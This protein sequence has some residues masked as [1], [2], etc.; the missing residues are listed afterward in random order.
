MKLFIKKPKKNCIVKVPIVMQMNNLE[1][2]VASLAMILSY[3]NLWIPLDNLRNDCL[4]DRNGTN[5]NSLIKAAESYNLIAQ[6]KSF[7]IK[8]LKEEAYY[9]LIINLNNQFVVLCGIKKDYAIINSPSKGKI[10]VDINDF[11]KMYDGSCLLFNPSKEFVTNGKQKSIISYAIK[12]L[13]NSFSAIL[14]IL[15]AYIISSIIG[16]IKPGFQRI[17]LDYILNKNSDELVLPFLISLSIISLF[18]IIM[19]A[20]KSKLSLQI[21]GRFAIVANTSFINKILYLPMS[22]FAEHMSGDLVQRQNEN[23]SIASILINTLSPLFINFILLIFYLV[24]MIRYSL[25]LTIIGVLSVFINLIMSRVISKLRIN[26]TRVKA[27][28]NGKLA[29][30]TVTGID[31]IETIKSSGAENAYFEKWSGYQM[32][33]NNDNVKYIKLNQYL[34]LI[35]Q[36]IFHISN[37]TILI[38]SV[39]FVINNQFSVGMVLAFQTLLSSFTSPCMSIIQANQTIQEMRTSMERIEDIMTYKNDSIV[40]KDDINENL[41]YKKLDGNIEIKNVSFSYSKFSNEVLSDIN[42]SIKKG[43]RIAI[44]GSSGCGK[45]TLAQLISS[46]YYPTKGSIL[47]DNK[48]LSE[49]DKTVFSSSLSICD[50][51]ILL[52]HDT[53]A[54]NI[55]MWDQTIS[56]D[57]MVR[58]AKD[59]CI[60]NII[61]NRSNGY[62]HIVKDKGND[63][64]GGERQRI[65]IARMLATNPSIIILDEAT[66]ALDAITEKNIIDNIK[67]RNI[68]CII[69]AHRLSTVRDCETIIVIDKGK[70]VEQGNH[71]ELYSNKNIYYNLIESE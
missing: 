49:I 35:P 71:N 25:I 20:C 26:L 6:Q 46:L 13:N 52:F 4:I 58:A 19:S 64:S 9:P 16:F 36:I 47:Y 60:D 65:E 62:Q 37:T 56:D 18:E 5:V 24:I 1:S 23:E 54:N 7:S 51:E 8:E 39:F 3:Y 40:L 12:R 66:S 67:N 38:L 55:K 70:I 50:Q 34:G 28:N 45:S 33:V 41:E 44:V 29:S 68:T 14:I 10:K 69:I 11:I 61:L 48:E 32:S 21:A 42:I 59:A 22:F 63:F 27:Q 17:F 53:I 2:G 30:C 57:D 31:M 43:E 15:F